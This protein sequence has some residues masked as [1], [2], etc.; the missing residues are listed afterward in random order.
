MRW[1]DNK[2]GTAQSTLCVDSQK[3]KTE[4]KAV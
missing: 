2:I 3:D 4:L 1:T